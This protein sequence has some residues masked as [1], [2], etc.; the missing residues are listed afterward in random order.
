M[1]FVRLSHIKY[2]F[3]RSFSSF[4]RM[5]RNMGMHVFFLSSMEICMQERQRSFCKR[6]CTCFCERCSTRAEP[7]AFIYYEVRKKTRFMHIISWL[8]HLVWLS[9]ILFMRLFSF[10][11]YLPLSNSIAHHEKYFVVESFEFCTRFFF[12]FYFY[13]FSSVIEK[14]RSVIWYYWVLSF[15]FSVFSRVCG[16]LES[17]RSDE[18]RN[19]LI[20]V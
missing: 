1:N 3:N 11:C 8:F 13:F 19:A 17:S 12:F 15:R 14:I 16:S 4:M 18:T 7:C 2:N 5:A 20:C 6:C 9:A 10:H